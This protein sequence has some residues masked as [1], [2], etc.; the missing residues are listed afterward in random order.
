M[1][2]VTVMRRSGYWW[3]DLRGAAMSEK[4]SKVLASPHISKLGHP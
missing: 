4:T 3:Y 2:S 1:P